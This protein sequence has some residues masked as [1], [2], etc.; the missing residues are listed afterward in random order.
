[1][2]GHT[3]VRKGYNMMTFGSGRLILALAGTAVIGLIG[4]SFTGRASAQAGQTPAGAK[5]QMAGEVFKNVTT[6]T[7]KGI[8]VDDFMGSMGVM[9]AAL[10]FDCSDCHTGAGTD[11]VVWDADTPKKRTAR[12]MVEMVAVINRTNFGGAQMVTC[13]TCH[14]GRDRPPTTIAL[15][16]LY[17][18][19]NEERDDII[20]AAPDQPS[21]DPI[22]DKY[23]QALGGAERLAGLT[24][25]VATA[26]GEGY[27]GLGGGGS[28]QILAKAPDQRTTII[29]FKDHPDRG[30]ST[31]TF[32]GRVGWI[33]TPRA[34][35]KEYELTGSELD[36]ARLDAQLSFPGQIKKVLTN[37]HAGFPDSINGHDVQ[38]VQG[39]GPRGLLATLYFDRQSGLLVRLVRYGRTP[40]GRVPTQ[41]DYSDYRDVGGIKFPFQYTFSWLDGKDSFKL[42]DVKTN[43]PIDPAK[44]DRPAPGMR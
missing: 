23:I 2:I 13:Y 39:T 9:S 1:M 19:P 11:K 26:S 36:G 14:H 24:S 32:N 31:R 30:D 37:L 7:L 38:V 28:V 21:A 10:G 17:G 3:R 40:I 41:V 42:S 22:L 8:T 5:G 33:K 44:F 4:I 27:E 16:T 25:F 18:P 6:S 35:L 12:K 29:Q 15:D 20:A 43:V 34:L